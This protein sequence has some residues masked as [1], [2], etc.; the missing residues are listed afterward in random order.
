MIKTPLYCTVVPGSTPD[1]NQ[2]F[3]NLSDQEIPTEERDVSLIW[4]AL[5]ID[6]IA[7]FF[8][9]FH[10]TMMFSVSLYALYLV[11]KPIRLPRN[12][13]IILYNP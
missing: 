8:I 4:D 6:E 7:T 5:T 13:A 9:S 3:G 2:S 10:F 12:D 11:F 1:Y